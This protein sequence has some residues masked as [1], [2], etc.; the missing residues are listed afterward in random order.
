VISYLLSFLRQKYSGRSVDDF[1]RDMPR[2]WLVW[3][4]G[5]WRPSRQV[6]HTMLALPAVRDDRGGEALAMALTPPRAGHA[7]LVLGRD[8]GSDLMVQDATVSR[9]HLMLTP[10]AQGG[11]TVR[12]GGSSN[13]TWVGDRKLEG[14]DSVELAS[15][16]SL[17]T[18]SVLLTFYDADGLFQRFWMVDPH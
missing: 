10:T 2:H 9:V 7:H 17:R 4:P 11:W 1:V 12:D 15:D 13:G 6:G 8:E 16:V 18:G 3:E 14:S 5:H